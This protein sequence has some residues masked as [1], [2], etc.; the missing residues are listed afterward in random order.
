MAFVIMSP[1]CLAGPYGFLSPELKEVWLNTVTEA[2]PFQVYAYREPV[3]AFGSLVP[4]LLAL[5]VAV[6]RLGRGPIEKRV[7]WIL[8]A[9]LLAAATALSFYQIRTLPFASAIA[10][11]ILGAWIAEVRASS[12]ARTTNP[13]KRSFPVGAAFLAAGQ[14]TY[15]LIGLLAVD[16]IAYAS[17]GRIAPPERPKPPE[18]LVKGL[19][20]AEK[21]CFD[22]ASGVL[23]SAVLR[24]LVLAPLFYGP[25]VL[26]LSPHDV[27]AGPYHRN[28]K[29]ILE[30]INATRRPPAEAKA[31]ID[32][33]H[34]DYVAV[35]AVSLETAIGAHKAP[36]GLVAD[37]NAGKIPPWLQPVAAPEKTG[38]RL[39]RVMR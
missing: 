10:I 35:C 21:N 22:P 20:E 39:W 23:L 8:P 9:T 14:V 6:R 28:G 24:G 3:G 19:T 38:L 2:Q 32:A 26:K 31:I 1:A 11:P 29:A 30:T 15:L 18:E 36:G 27:V 5:F 37:L 16:A 12:M 34:I 7:V 4:L 13:L 17:D 25:T 33:R